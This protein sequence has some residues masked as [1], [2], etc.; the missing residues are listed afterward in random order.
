MTPTR[1]GY[2]ALVTGA[3]SG[4]GQAIALAFGRD[5]ARVV[6]SDVDEGRSRDTAQRIAAE[7][8]AAIAVPC[9]VTH[10]SDVDRLIRQAVDA[11]GRLDCA[12]N[13]AGISRAGAPL[14]E[15]TEEDYDAVLAVNLKGVWLSMKYE[16]TQM[17]A[18]GGGAIV[19]LASAA[20]LIG[21]PNAAA[22]VASKHGVVGLTRTAALE[23]ASHGIRVNAVCPGYVR[24]PMTLGTGKPD[25]ERVER[26]SAAHPLGRMGTPEEIAA[27]VLWLASDAAAFVTGA[28]IPIDGGYTAR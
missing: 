14:H 3:G 16:I 25:P 5:G 13:N 20:G 15:M 11:Y 27:L 8:G 4:I 28:A 12:V 9:D 21:L 26:M 1:S 6:V 23:V 10:A 22:Y 24:S 17:I 2:V 19:N 7:G 18:Q